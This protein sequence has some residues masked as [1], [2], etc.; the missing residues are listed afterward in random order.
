MEPGQLVLGTV[1]SLDHARLPQDLARRQ[2]TGRR[3]Q[4]NAL[5]M[6]LGILH[7]CPTYIPLHDEDITS[8]VGEQ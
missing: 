2:T 3:L 5:P 4:L 8:S 7:V 1:G 6:S